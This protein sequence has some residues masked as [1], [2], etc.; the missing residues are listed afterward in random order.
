MYHFSHKYTQTSSATSTHIP[1]QPQACINHLSHKHACTISVTNNNVP[2]QPQTTMYY[3]S[4]M[5]AYMCGIQLFT[6]ISQLQ[7]VQKWVAHIVT[8]AHKFGHIAPVLCYLHWLPI[9][10][11]ITYKAVVLTYHA[12]TGLA[13]PTCGNLLCHKDHQEICALPVATPWLCQSLG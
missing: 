3:F 11:R 9:Q 8:R 6:T 13:Q 10:Q 12:L 7:C 1:V 4:H 5:A 2:F